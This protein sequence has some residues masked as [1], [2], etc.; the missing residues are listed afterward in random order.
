MEPCIL[1]ENESSTLFVIDIPTSIERVQG[2]HY[3]TQSRL[4]SVEP[5]QRPYPSTEPSSSKKRSKFA[6]VPLQDLLL[7]KHL[8][9]AVCELK[10]RSEIKWCLDRETRQQIETNIE[11]AKADGTKAGDFYS[12]LSN[13]AIGTVQNSGCTILFLENYH[14]TSTRIS[15]AGNYFRLPPR[16]TALLGPLSETID[17]FV[18]Q[19]PI[20]NLITIDPPWPNRSARRK[21]DYQ[22]SYGLSEIKTLLLTIPLAAHCVDDG[23]VAVWVTNKP[24]FRSLLLSLFDHW[25][26]SLAEE[27]VWLKIT[28]QGEPM[29]K[30]TGLWRKPYEV[31][32]IG[33]KNVASKKCLQVKRRVILG[34]PDL[35]SRKPNMNQILEKSFGLKP[36]EYNGLEIFARNLSAGWWGWGND[37]LKFQDEKYWVDLQRV[38]NLKADQKAREKT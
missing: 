29:C 2:F 32:L 11:E 38:S 33:C 35:H 23:I 15:W 17:T 21:A 5:L 20:F 31:L 34:V 9:L 1:Y 16:S 18:K 12:P 28:A 37:I 10:A 7:Q 36:G 8:E 4:L 3:S 13:Q 26:L 25:G 24:A 14:A 22:I 30:L 6:E 27:W 19:A